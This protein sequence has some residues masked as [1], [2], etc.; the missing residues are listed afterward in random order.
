LEELLSKKWVTWECL[1]AFLG[2]GK[3]LWTGSN[4]FMVSVHF[5]HS[6]RS[7]SWTRTVVSQ[8]D[9]YWV[10][11]V[12]VVGLDQVPAACIGDFLVGLLAKSEY[13]DTCEI[14][15]FVR[16]DMIRLPLSE[17]GL[18]KI[19]TESNGTLQKLRLDGF[20]LKQEHFRAMANALEDRPT[21]AKGGISPPDQRRLKRR[22][23]T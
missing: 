20:D 8:Y 12:S 1:N 6:Y 2:D 3:I 9:Y 21:T 11:S 5:R 16:G 7:G 19:L 14:Q 17:R 23:C 15:S 18:L 22:R 4:T 13:I 10:K